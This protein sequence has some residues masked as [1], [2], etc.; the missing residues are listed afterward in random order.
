MALRYEVKDRHDP[1]ARGGRSAKLERA[2]R[3]LA[4]SYPP[5]RFYIYDREEKREVK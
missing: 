4:K 3:E 5:G 2:R 1:R